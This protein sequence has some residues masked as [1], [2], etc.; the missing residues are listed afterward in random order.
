[1]LFVPVNYR[2][3]EYGLNALTAQQPGALVLAD[4]ATA[5]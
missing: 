3:D 4:E 5:R 1:M 2:L